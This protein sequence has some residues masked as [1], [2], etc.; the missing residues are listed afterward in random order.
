MKRQWSVQAQADIRVGTVIAVELF[1]QARKPAY[2]LTLDLGMELGHKRSSAQITQLYSVEDLIDKQVV[3]VVNLA[4]KRIGG[5]VS[6]VLVL[7]APDEQGRVVLLAPQRAVPNGAR[8][9]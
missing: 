8:I 6:E 7:G 5:F 3:A 4:P 9:F 2:K 1:P